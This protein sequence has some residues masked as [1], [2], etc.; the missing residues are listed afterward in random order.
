MVNSSLEG[1]HKLDKGGLGG[2]PAQDV[3][4]PRRVV[5]F[6]VHPL[7][8]RKRHLGR[9]PAKEKSSLKCWVPRSDKT[10]KLLYFLLNQNRVRGIQTDMY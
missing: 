4:D 10:S 9:A 1:G 6:A 8:P 3:A 5:L 2:T 7:A